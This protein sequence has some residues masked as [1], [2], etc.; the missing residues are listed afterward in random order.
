[1]FDCSSEYKGEFISKS[2]L[3][4]PDLANKLTCVLIR[5]LQEVVAFRSDIEEMFHQVKSDKRL[6]T[7]PSILMAIRRYEKKVETY[8]T[9][10]HL[11]GAASLQVIPIFSVP[12]NDFLDNGPKTVPFVDGAICKTKK[13]TVATSLDS[14]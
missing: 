11:C 7:S 3:T 14:A 13:C 1:M 8:R 6:L 10:V 12:E 9:T 5:F 4:S 2:L